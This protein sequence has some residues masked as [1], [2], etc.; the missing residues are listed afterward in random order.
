MRL[1]AE[2]EFSDAQAETTVASHDSDNIYDMNVAGDAE[3]ALWLNARVNTAFTSGGAGTLR[4]QAI[5]DSDNGFATTPVIFEDTGVLA[6]ATLVAG[7]TFFKKRLPANMQQHVKLVYIIGTAAM[8]GG[9]I[10][11]Y[12]APDVD[13]KT[14]R[15]N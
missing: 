6:L 12:L 1:D 5:H 9:S 15:S 11:A 4:V 2:N 3:K 7:Y 13:H 10:D 14:N 8:T